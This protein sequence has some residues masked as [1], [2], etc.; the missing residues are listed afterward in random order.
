MDYREEVKKTI[1][2]A[3]R[4]HVIEIK[5]I[6]LGAQELMDFAAQRI[7]ASATKSGEPNSKEYNTT[8]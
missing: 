1:C 8:D 7:D 2:D 4:S 5:D 6:P 3:S